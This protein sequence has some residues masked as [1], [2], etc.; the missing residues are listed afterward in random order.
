M[1]R[2]LVRIALITTAVMFA[3]AGGICLFFYQ[4]ARQEPAFYRQA[5][6]VKPEQQAEAG[7]QLEKEVLDLRNDVLAAG[8]WEAVFTEEQI[9]GWLAVDLPDKFPGM[10]PDGV[11]SPRVEIQDG[12]VSIAARYEDKLMSSVVSIVL[13]VCL[14]DEANTVAVTIQRV[15]AGALPVPVRQFLDRISRTAQRSDISLRWSQ[16]DGDPVAFV[17]IPSRSDD[18]IHQEIFIETIELR[19]GEVYLAGRTDEHP[20]P[21]PTV[22]QRLERGTAAEKETS[23]R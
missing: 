13:G 16:D 12:R 7:Q 2:R 11:E 17:T 9:N 21:P 10:L 3:L 4:A 18:Y 6:L 19:D 22:A 1:V 8:R 15:R 5:M 20:P 14:T 23:Q